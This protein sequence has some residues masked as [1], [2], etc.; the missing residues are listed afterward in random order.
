MVLQLLLG[1]Y[2]GRYYD[3]SLSD[4]GV[5]LDCGCAFGRIHLA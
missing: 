2:L 1:L 4:L 3:N 5:W